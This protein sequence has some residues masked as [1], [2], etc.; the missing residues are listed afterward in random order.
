[1]T[2]SLVR[3]CPGLM[4]LKTKA[5]LKPEKKRGLLPVEIALAKE[6]NDDVAAYLIRQ[7]SHVR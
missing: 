1:M 7:M 2:K 4:G 5:I 6:K 3:K